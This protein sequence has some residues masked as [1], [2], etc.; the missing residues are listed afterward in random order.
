M[1]VRQPLRP[2]FFVPGR[3]FPPLG[4][5]GLVGALPPRLATTL[6]PAL[7]VFFPRLAPRFAGGPADFS[8]DLGFAFRPGAAASFAVLARAAV[9]RAAGVRRALRRCAALR[10]AAV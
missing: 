3:D 8:L 10:V 7:A 2:R 6:T 9:A 4:R 1:A 5:S